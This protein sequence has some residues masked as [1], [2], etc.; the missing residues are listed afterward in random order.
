M[1]V[2]E[3]DEVL[4]RKGDYELIDLGGREKLEKFGDVT[5]IRPEEGALLAPSLS[6]EK[7]EALAHARFVE[8]KGRKGYWEELNPHPEE[9]TVSFPLGPFDPVFRVGLTAGKQVGVFPE[10]VFNWQWI[11]RRVADI[12]QTGPRVLNLFAYTGGASLVA[13]AAG[14]DV[15][16]VESHRKAITWAR[17]NLEAN[18]MEGVR[19]VVEDAWKFVQRER[20]RGRVYQ[21][22]VLDPPAWGRGPK[23]ELWR[24]KTDGPALIRALVS[25]LPPKG[26]F[27]LLNTY[28]SSVA[29]LNLK[30]ALE[31]A[32]KKRKGKL[33]WGKQI[34]ED[35]AG[36]TYE[37]GHFFR[38]NGGP[39]KGSFSS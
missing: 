31:K 34:L 11:Y 38:W 13:K 25:L 35:R 21:G 15:F 33:E 5:L 39:P 36:K 12:P 8:Q 14:G 23:G 2:Q 30:V 26:G 9:W 16:H 24:L 10:Q 32:L 18:G 6:R 28:S 3:K 7:R 37:A 20:K 4:H 17:R 19:W 29:P 22:I 27:L 1:T